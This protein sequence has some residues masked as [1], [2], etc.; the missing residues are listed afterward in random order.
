MEN[1]AEAEPVG[2]SR[3]YVTGLP[4]YLDEKRLRDIF[5]ERG[6]VTDAKI[7]RTRLFPFFGNLSAI[8]LHIWG[9]AVLLCSRQTC[10]AGKTSSDVY[11]D[12]RSRQFGFVGFQTVDQ[13]GE[14]IHYFDKSYIDTSR[15]QVKVACSTPAGIHCKEHGS[16]GQA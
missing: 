7:M 14:A 9:L 12:G 8:G 5:S 6:E 11:R 13:A 1:E 4:T 3:I 16:W 10:I 15:L 2:S